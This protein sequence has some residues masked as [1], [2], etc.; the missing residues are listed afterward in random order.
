[1]T[2]WFIYKCLVNRDS[3]LISVLVQVSLF[4][5]HPWGEIMNC[6]CKHVKDSY[7]ARIVCFSRAAWKGNT[8]ELFKLVFWT[9]VVL[10]VLHK[11]FV[12][13]FFPEI[14]FKSILLVYFDSWETHPKAKVFNAS[15]ITFCKMSA[16]FFK[17]KI[18]NPKYK[19][20]IKKQ[21]RDNMT[22]YTTF[23]Y[24]G[25]TVIDG[26]ILEASAHKTPS[27]VFD[28]EL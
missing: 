16:R 27:M 7:I 17:N 13:I 5:T 18:K 12:H 4:I 6:L 10:I 20:L 25:M 1:M 19:C 3:C 14:S 15:C 24:Q 9:R 22:K 21:Q 8:R 28:Y 23:F 26:Q 11:I 2:K